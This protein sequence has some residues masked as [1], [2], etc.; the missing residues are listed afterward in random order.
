M[1]ITKNPIPE[2]CSDAEFKALDDKNFIQENEL[3]NYVMRREFKKLRETNRK[4]VCL[5]LLQ[6]Q[7]PYLSHDSIRGIVNSKN[8]KRKELSL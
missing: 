2:L 4:E 6:L 5:D 1:Q 7:F 8:Y 3:R